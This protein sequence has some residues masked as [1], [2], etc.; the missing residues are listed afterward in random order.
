MYIWLSLCDTIYIMSVLTLHLDKITKHNTGITYCSHVTWKRND[1]WVAVNNEF[2]VT[3]EVIGQWFSR[4]ANDFHEWRSDEWN[5]WQIA[6]RVTQKSPF[7]VTN[8]SFYFLHA[9]L[10]FW[11]H[12]S[13]KNN[14]RSLISPLS[15]RMVFSDLALWRHHSWS[16]TSRER[17]VLTLWRH[18]RR[19]F[20]HVHIGTKAI[21]TS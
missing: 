20:L 12:N 9:Y 19:L 15:L 6:S 5:H 17:G 14:Y 11:I 8:V 2:W 10:M 1:A 18:T 3:S 7:T 21:F 16:V 4:L 13:A